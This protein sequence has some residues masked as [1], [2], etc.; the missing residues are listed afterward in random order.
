MRLITKQLA[1]QRQAAYA[2]VL[3]RLTKT[4][5]RDANKSLRLQQAKAAFAC[6]TQL[7]PD[8]IYLLVDDVVT[9]GATMKYAAKALQAAGA[10]T[11]WVASISRQPLD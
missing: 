3:G 7:D 8:A 10:R 9:T 1:K 5:Q 11:I 2:P 4:K 6:S